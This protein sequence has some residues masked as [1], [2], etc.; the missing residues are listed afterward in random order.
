MDVFFVDWRGHDIEVSEDRARFEVHGYGKTSD[1]Q[2]ILVRVVTNPYFFVKFNEK[3]S[4]ARQSAWLSNVKKNLGAL[5]ISCLLKRKDMAGFKNGLEEPFAC[6]AFASFAE[7]RK[8]RFSMKYPNYGSLATY[9]AGLDPV[10]RMFHQRGIDPSGWVRVNGYAPVMDDRVSTV[11]L[12]ITVAAANIGKSD[13]TTVPELVLASWDLECVSASG[14]FPDASLPED[15]LITIGVAFQKHGFPGPYRRVAIC[16]G[17]TAAVPGNVEVVSCATEGEMC[18][19]FQDILRFEKTDILVGYNILGFDFKY[20]DGR[21][22][23]LTDD[24]GKPTIKFS[25]LGRAVDGC[26]VAVKK[27]LSSSAFGDNN[28]EYLATP[29]ILQIDLLQIFRKE[30]KLDSYSLKNVST[31][32]LSDT[33]IDLPPHEIFA[34]FKSGTPDD[35]ATIAEYCIRDVELPLRLMDK[36]ST[37]ENVLQMSNATCV[38][39]EFLQLRGQQIRVYSLITRKGRELGFVV[40]DPPQE[41]R[42]ATP[43]EK[44]AGATVL[45]PAKGF[46]TE[47]VCALDFASLY[48]SIIR[49]HRMCL[50]TLVTD[51]AYANVEGVE[52]YSILTDSGTHTFAQTKNAVLPGLLED[53]AACRKASKIDMADAYARGD[54]FA[55]GIHNAKQ[56][57]YKITSNSVYGTFG[58]TRG[59][60]TC[61]PIAQSVTATGRSMIDQT[62]MLA[63]SLVPGSKVVYGD[64]DSVFV[65][66]KVD[67]GKEQDLAEHFRVATE[68]SA[69]ISKTFLAPNDLEF[70]KVYH[71]FLLVGKKR[72]VGRNY[73]KLTD[74]GVIDVKGLQLVRRDNAPIVKIV[75]QKIMDHLMIEMDAGKAVDAARAMILSVLR[76]ELPLENYVVTKALRSNYANPGA[77]PHAVVARKILQRTGCAVTS[78]ERVPFCFVEDSANLDGGISS[79]AEDPGWV[80]ENGLHVDALYYVNNQLMNPITTLLEHVVENVD[81]EILGFPGIHVIMLEMKTRR[82]LDLKVCKRLKLNSSRGQN[83]ITSFFKSSAKKPKFIDD[84]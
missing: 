46:Y 60:L 28:F 26:G 20:L 40:P 48:P 24:H 56:L 30:L 11:D 7:M 8:A 2:E 49:A 29:G 66:F 41:D 47:P 42:N 38:P 36:L 9:E 31:K 81:S 71:P 61:L 83:E 16:L 70:E 50:S 55:A 23:C 63:E 37:L 33:K 45:E 14:M 21:R 51:P 59:M 25:R 34:K 27:N 74:L 53:L 43:P 77:Q 6:L 58:A 82:A 13:R 64:T 65:K 18:E 79:R 73:E 69:E 72:Y 57:A 5:D 54:T 10:L 3:Y 4:A 35:L 67:A 22:A 15:Q 78:G 44:Y 75:S 32:F 39:P 19:I 52:Y 76:G 12:E 68:V 80:R 1:N 84:S 17:E 62:K